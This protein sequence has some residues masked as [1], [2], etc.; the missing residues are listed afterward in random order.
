MLKLPNYIL[1]IYEYSKSY[2]AFVGFIQ[3]KIF[4]ED[5]VDAIDRLSDEILKFEGTGSYYYLEFLLADLYALNDDSLS[6]LKF[7]DK[8]IDQNP[9]PI[10]LRSAKVKR[11]LLLIG[12][13]YLREY[14]I[15]PNNKLNKIVDLVKVDPN[16]Y[17]LQTLS[18][19]IENGEGNYVDFIDLVKNS[20]KSC[21]YKTE[22]YFEL[23]KLAY[24]NLDFQ[25]AIQFGNQA[26]KKSDF[27]NKLVI[28][29]HL[30]KINWV[31]SNSLSQ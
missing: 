22:T 24:K 30:S 2:S 25:N 15:S 14:M 19:L 27:K 20:I 8:I 28:Q 16:D 21:S 31:S 13:N 23:S 1:D 26:L 11:Q 17:L 7:Y 12:N 9:H 4:L 5:K 29:D 6:A 3:S 10:Y 18:V